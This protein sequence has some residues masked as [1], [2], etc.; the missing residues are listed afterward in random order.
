MIRA[1]T[2]KAAYM[3]IW[4]S[5]MMA[6]RNVDIAAFDRTA[7]TPCACPKTHKGLNSICPIVMKKFRPRKKKQAGLTSNFCTKFFRIPEMERQGEWI[8]MS[9]RNGIACLFR[10]G[11]VIIW[12][13]YL[14]ADCPA[15]SMVTANGWTLDTPPDKIGLVSDQSGPAIPYK[16]H[17]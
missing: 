5:I 6:G 11:T 14:R 17:Q 8:R 7:S 9:G 4:L 3:E 10:I 1:A 16:H 2:P 12:V 13:S 15:L